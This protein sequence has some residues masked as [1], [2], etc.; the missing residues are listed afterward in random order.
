MKVRMLEIDGVF[1]ITP[2]RHG[3]ERGFFSETWSRRSLAEAGADMDFV[4]DNQS[5][6]AA[7]GT[8]RGLHFQTPPFAQAKLVRVVSGAV[9]DVAVD[10]RVGSPTFGRWVGLE[11][12]R[13]KWN[14]L[15]VPVGFAHGF[16]TLVPDT[17]VSYKVSN[18]YSQE[19]DRAIRFDDPA[20]GVDWPRSLAPF[21]VSPKDKD[22]PR[23][24]EIEPGFVY[25]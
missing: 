12:S 5:M 6:S 7:V 23:L 10:I 17:E 2:V 8:L 25:E 24:A 22:A 15:F 3:D 16:V 11:L 21:Q 13:E 1:E 19:H 9:L 20:I 4:Q 14:Q 18:Y